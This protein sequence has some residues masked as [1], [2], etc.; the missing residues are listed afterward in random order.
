[1]TL[2][3]SSIPTINPAP[4]AISTPMKQF[5]PTIIRMDQAEAIEQT[6]VLDQMRHVTIGIMEHYSGIHPVHGDCIISISG[7]SAS[8]IPM[9]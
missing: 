8:L 5:N 2:V 6:Y 4:P 1:M 9:K 3:S 7:D